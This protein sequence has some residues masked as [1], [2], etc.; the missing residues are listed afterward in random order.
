MPELQ[1]QAAQLRAEPDS[2]SVWGAAL[3]G[4]G[5]SLAGRRAGAPL[6]PSGGD[7][8]SRGKAGLGGPPPGLASSHI[9]REKLES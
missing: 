4:A 2:C 9:F 5:C 6:T 8:D 1:G 7:A 3:E